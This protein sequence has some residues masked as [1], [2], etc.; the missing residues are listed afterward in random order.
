[1]NATACERRASR[2]RWANLMGALPLPCAFNAEPGFVFICNCRSEKRW[3]DFCSLRRLWFVHPLQWIC[4]IGMLTV[5]KQR[6]LVNSFIP[7]TRLLATSSVAV[8]V[9][10]ALEMMEAN[11]AAPASG[12]TFLCFPLRFIFLGAEAQALEASF[13]SCACCIA[14]LKTRKRS[15]PYGSSKSD[16]E[17]RGLWRRCNSLG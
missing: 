9:A 11:E 3:A 8:F 17:M 15:L 12:S 5:F 14:I 10:C 7:F 13:G 4:V 2:R 6:S 16:R 1:M